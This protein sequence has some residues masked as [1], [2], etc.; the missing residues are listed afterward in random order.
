MACLRGILVSQFYSN[1]LLILYLQR[2]LYL[3]GQVTSQ[4]RLLQGQ[5]VLED[6]RKLSEYS[7][8]EGAM[9]SA[10][11]EPDVD[12]EIEVSTGQQVQE[13]KVSNATSIKELKTQINGVM[14]SGLA[15]E[16]L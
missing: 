11:F 2:R 6:H 13:L 14:R 4:V 12:I 10:L 15:P 7:L 3:S 5:T 16:K 9:I 8:Q 1:T